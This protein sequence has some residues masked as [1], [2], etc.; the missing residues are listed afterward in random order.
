MT[1]HLCKRS[2]AALSYAS[3]LL[4]A[5]L[6]ASVDPSCE[7]ELGAQNRDP[8]VGKRV[9]S[10]FLESLD[11]MLALAFDPQARIFQ[12]DQTR[13]KYTF[14][15]DQKEFA[16][17]I[18]TYGYFSDEKPI[19]GR[20]TKDNADTCAVTELLKQ[21]AKK[22]RDPLQLE[23]AIG[24]AIA[25][26]L[27]YRDLKEG[28]ILNL[29]R[30][31]Q[32]GRP[33]FTTYKVDQV[34]DLWHKMPAF[35]LVPQE[36]GVSALLLFRGTDFSLITERGWASLISDLEIRDPGYYAFVQAEP[37]L[38]TWL[39]KDSRSRSACACDRF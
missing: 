36:K 32:T 4:S 1:P 13:P 29:P 37:M 10:T 28:Q 18:K 11:K 31:D 33:V 12:L 34:F 35:G 21:M 16:E 25:K 19:V 15:S 9:R 27:A 23:I 2:L 7:A 39:A 24:E 5:P 17:F 30:L 14:R 26:I 38:R 22:I 3:L 8:T 6:F 20:V